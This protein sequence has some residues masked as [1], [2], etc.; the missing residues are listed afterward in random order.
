MRELRVLHSGLLLQ[1]RSLARAAKAPCR[2]GG[3]G[4]RVVPS[5]CSGV[6]ALAYSGVAGVVLG[7]GAWGSCGS[8]QGP[9][10]G[11]SCGPTRPWDSGIV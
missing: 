3:P 8:V 9:G 5:A 4:Q 1:P 7:V 6:K 2:L 10:L 11:W